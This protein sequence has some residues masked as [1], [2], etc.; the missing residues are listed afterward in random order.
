MNKEIIKKVD[1]AREI[2]PNEVISFLKPKLD[3]YKV[4]VEKNRV[5]FKEVAY[6]FLESDLKFGEMISRNGDFEIFTKE[7]YKE[8]LDTYYENDDT[9][10]AFLENIIYIVPEGNKA[11]HVL[12]ELLSIETYEEYLKVES[13]GKTLYRECMEESVHVLRDEIVDCEC[14]LDY[15][16]SEDDIEECLNIEIKADILDIAVWRATED[17]RYG[18]EE[19]NDITMYIDGYLYDILNKEKIDY[20]RIMR[21][22]NKM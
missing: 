13:I 10:A 18:L 8:L 7:K 15:P 1:F 21:I 5:N 2:S 14:A 17:K 11:I 4:K 12:D 19:F 6:K 3:E 20:N 9:F 16:Y 22:I